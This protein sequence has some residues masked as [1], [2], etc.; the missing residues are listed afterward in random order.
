MQPTSKLTR[1]TRTHERRSDALLASVR[2]RAPRALGLSRT[3]GLAALVVASFPLAA[4]AESAT[5]KG[6]ELQALQ[7]TSLLGADITQVGETLSWTGRGTLAVRDPAGTLVVTLNSGDTYTT[8]TTGE[9]SLALSRDQNADWTIAVKRGATE[10]LGRVFGTRWNFYTGDFGSSFSFDGS[11]YALVP[12]G[13]PNSDGVIEFKAAGWS[14]NE[15]TLTANRSGIAGANGRSVGGSAGADV[16]EYKIY[17]SPPEIAHYSLIAPSV[18]GAV[19]SAGSQDCSFVVPG[20]VTGEFSFDSNVEGTYHVV[21]DLNQDGTFDI[22]SDEDLHIL[23]AATPG[24]NIVTWEGLDNNGDLIP[25]G[26]YQCRVLLSVGEFHY[27][28]WDVETSYQGFRL[29][30]VDNAGNRAGLPMYWNDA[31]VAAG[32]VNMPNGVKGLPTSGANGLNAGLYA[33]AASAN[34]NARSWGHFASDGKGDVSYMDTYTFLA[35]DLSGTL[36]V[37]VN[38]GTTDG[39]NDGL[40]D[41]VEDCELGTDYL[42]NDTDND[43]ITDGDEVDFYGTD[44]L[45]ADTDDDGLSDG[46]EV[47]GLDQTPESGDETDP[48]NPDTDDDGLTDGLE[49][50]ID[51]PVPGG[52]SDELNVPY[53]GTD[54]GPDSPWAPDTDTSTTTDPLDEDSDHDTLRDGDE[55]ADQDGAW[56]GDQPGTSSDEADPNDPDSDDD[57]LRDDAEGGSAGPDSDG[58]ETIDALDVC[59]GDD[60]TGDT[61]G[62]GECDSDDVCVG[63]DASGD[64]DG[65]GV[66]DDTDICP[67]DALDDSD[68]DGV[69]DSDDQCVG[70]DAS[71]DTDGDGLCDD[72][73]P[74]VNDAGNDADGDGLCADVEEDLGT[75]PNDDDS[76]D[77]GLLDSTEDTNG[78]GVVDPGETDPNDFDSDDDGLGDGQE[79]GLTDPE[80]DD[81]NSGTF[82]P[83]ADPTTT[84]NPLDDDSDDDGLLDGT[85]DANHDGAQ[86]HTVGGTGDQGSGET[87]PNDVDSDHDGIQD[88]TESGLE[89]PEGDDT[90]LGV[91]VP[92]ADP[93]TVTDPLDVDTD[94]GSVSDGDE[95]VNA[96]GQIDAGETDPNVGADDVAVDDGDGDGIPDDVEDADG[97]GVVDPGETDP[98]DTDSDDD[99][100]DD[101][102]EDSNHN[103]VVDPGETDP[104]NPDTDGDGFDDGV[105][106]DLGTDGSVYTRV[107]GSG[108]DVGGA[109]MGGRLG[110]VLGL[111]GLAL[112]RRRRAAVATVAAAA[113]ATVSG[114]ALAQDA[115][116]PKLDIQRFDPNVQDRTF[117]L[118]RDGQQMGAG[119]FG[120]HLA[121]NYG[122][123]PL[124]LGE[125][126][127]HTRRV[128]IVDHLIGFDLGFNYAPTKW[129]ELGLNLP[130]LQIEGL[131]DTDKKVGGLLGSSGKSVG[132][133]DLALAFGFAPL[134]QG[135]NGPASLSIVP[136]FVLPTGSRGEFLGSGT[137]GVGADIAFAQRFDMFRYALNLGYQFNAASAPVHNVYADDELRFGAAI[138]IPIVDSQWEFD[139][140]WSGG[141]VLVPQGRKDLGDVWD[142]MVH[143][144]MEVV[145]AAMYA[146]EEKPYW[147]KF[148]AGPGLTHGYGTPDVRVFAEVGF[149]HWAEAALDTDHDGLID[150]LDKCP[151][152]PE[153]FDTFEDTDGCPDLDN[154]HDGVPD[155]QDGHQANGALVFADGLKGFG[156]CM[157]TPEDADG[158]ESGDG[159]PELDNDGDGVPDTRDGHVVNGSMAQTA[160]FAGF[161]DC[162]NAPEDADGF[163]SDD[164]CPDLDNDRDGIVDVKDGHRKPDG[165]VSAD[166]TYAGFGDCMNEPE[167][168]NAV[169]DDDGCADQALAQVDVV[170]NEIVILDKVYFDY[171]KATIKKASYPV[172]EAVQRVLQAYPD[173]L[174]VEIQGHTDTRG[175]DEYNRKLSQ[176]RV[177]SVLEWLVSHGVERSR[178]VAKGYGE[179]MLLVPNA[180]TEDEHAKNRRVQ[181][182]VVEKAAGGVEV[183]DAGQAEPTKPE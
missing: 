148:G 5:S 13:G 69:C 180:Q 15:W 87:N 157:N 140:E 178:L 121:I 18:T 181:F 124:E 96:N 36:T 128:G 91:F 165:T 129:L 77:D 33:A 11:M 160:G 141:A 172:L 133:G 70:D 83:D 29:F 135:D 8:V 62:D 2:A 118:V 74:C 125:G 127:K 12:G 99:G 179:S 107:Q 116:K 94:D 122:L 64:T 14:G 49:L 54:T 92:D 109:P 108:C 151:T 98:T 50:G 86:V 169:D 182:V 68:G 115:A 101:G 32:D 39:D 28:A 21:C 150:D 97:D 24:N 139:V 4:H 89:Q 17:L 7:Q 119:Q 22:T 27:T 164:G 66:C 30:S 88:G 152:E 111:L 136:R 25:S 175:S 93:T 56:D 177:D 95:D 163:Q 80:G 65:D 105:E 159:C 113:M 35:Y 154:D 38:D 123:N 46:D 71:G 176:A 170:T 63:D 19:F 167:V 156:D 9:F 183:R 60:A 161:G 72:S 82:I 61:D 85:E 31:A 171:D 20:S 26:D 45:D 48:L 51:T 47:Y 110:G 58:D 117:T 112:V 84:T 37:N 144:P 16:P 73:D 75:D 131:T 153:D 162:M 130:V 67:N 81:T 103:G 1:Q 155:T 90:N 43:G 145:A 102:D 6:L 79:G 52:V 174:K 168:R 166:A 42:D 147:V 132:L 40:A 53:L 137:V 55:D 134:R 41:Y 76:D 10:Q 173:L 44:P 23:G 104:A 34:V 100:L 138:G 143:A 57:G 59:V 146:P 126:D 142:P 158:F 3:L 149:G 78:N 106:K 120:G 114:N